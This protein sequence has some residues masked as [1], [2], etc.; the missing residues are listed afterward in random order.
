M[1]SLSNL[2]ETYREYS[3]DPTDDLIKFWK[4]EVKITAGHCVDKGIHVDGGAFT[5]LFSDVSV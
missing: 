1:N 2:D 3:I 4:S 5:I